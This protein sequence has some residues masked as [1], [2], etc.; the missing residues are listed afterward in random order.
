MTINYDSLVCRAAQIRPSERQLAWQK[1]ELTAFIH[2]TINTFTDKEWGDGTEDINIFNPVQC[3][4]RQWVRELKA[5]GFKMIILTTKHHDG[6]CL[7]PSKYTEHSIKN[8]PYKNGSGNIVKEFVDAC[9]EYGVK[10]GFYLSPWDR[11]EESYGDS[12]LYNE[13]FINQLRELCTEY[14]KIYCFW[15]DG[16][17][18][19][20]PNGK[21]QEYDW[22]AYY[23]L[24]RELQPQ[25]M[26]SDIGPDARWCGN[27]AGRGRDAEWSVVNM[28][29][30]ILEFNSENCR[31]EDIG[32]LEALGGGENLVW[33]PSEVD[34]SNRPGWFWHESENNRVKSVGELFY[35]YVNSIGGN[36]TLLLNFPPDTRGLLHENDVAVLKEFKQYLDE[37]FKDNLIS[38]AEISAENNSAK[39]IIDGDYDSYWTVEEGQ[40]TAEIIFDIQEEKTFNCIVMQEYIPIGQRISEFTI[41]AEINNVWQEIAKG[42]TVGYKRIL[43]FDDITA[44]KIKLSINDSRLCPSLNNFELYKIQKLDSAKDT[45]IGSD[46]SLWKV[47]SGSGEVEHEVEKLFDGIDYTVWASDSALPCEMIIDMGESKE[48]KGFSFLPPQ[49]TYNGHILKYELSFAN[50][51]ED[52]N[53]PISRAFDNTVNNP[54]RQFINLDEPQSLRYFKLK[55]IS[56]VNDYKIAILTDIDI[57]E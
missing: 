2:F 25:A 45:N 19:E 3:D 50:T 8:S 29:K 32:S 21:V 17:C 30:S 37:T 43:I 48:I 53:K 46:R 44:S 5:T 33:H 49:E 38:N 16:A 9:N 14:G 40:K 26:I 31:L 6:F 34:T 11:H 22:D 15:F 20:G 12:P 28:N 24:I 52:L 13:Y 4:P 57:I 1:M 36:A 51:V 10:P 7:W 56:C 18:A 42:Q 47:I 27:E 55:V 39:N 23:S 41:E 35:I 54:I